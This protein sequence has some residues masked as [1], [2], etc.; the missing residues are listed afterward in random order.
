MVTWTCLVTECS[1]PLQ[2]IKAFPLHAA[3]RS[4]G[5]QVEARRKHQLQRHV[6]LETFVVLLYSLHRR[7]QVCFIVLRLVTALSVT[8]ITFKVLTLE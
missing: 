4:A 5:P 6:N 1:E 7:P 3:R 2:S 8:S